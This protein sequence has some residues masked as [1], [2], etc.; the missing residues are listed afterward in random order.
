[1]IKTIA[2]YFIWFILYSTL[3]WVY[4]SI[5]CSIKH[6]KL[7]NRGFLNGPYCPIYGSGA[8][9]IILV[10]GRV[11]N[12]PSLFMSGAVLACTLEYLTSYVMEKLFSARW[13]DYS[14]SKFNLNGRVCLAG[15]IVFGTFAVAL[16]K[17]IHPLVKRLTDV[18]PNGVIYI[19]ASV[20]LV[21]FVADNIITIMGMMGM[22]EKLLEISE[23][24][25]LKKQEAEAALSKEK[26]N[27]LRDNA[28]AF[29]KEKLNYQQIRMIEAFP[30]LKSVKYEEALEDIKELWE[31]IKNRKN[32]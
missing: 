7:I 31:K 21:L 23:H 10:L 9:V 2:T 15:A 20:L 13:W 1:M 16:V 26:F 32:M 11:E 27:A 8:I 14:D 6:K 22:N 12:I 28:K 19:S 30:K 29:L 24:I 5:Y 25:K 18:V 4:E 17:G 3:G